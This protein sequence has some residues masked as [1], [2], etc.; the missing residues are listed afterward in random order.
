MD[1]Y[2]GTNETFNS[3]HSKKIVDSKSAIDDT[4]PWCKSRMTATQQ[5]GKS[6]V[7]NYTYVTMFGREARCWLSPL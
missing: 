5:L 2:M 6:G 1:E 4:H 7:G 3:V